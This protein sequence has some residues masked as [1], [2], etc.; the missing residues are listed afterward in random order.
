MDK[1]IIIGADHAGFLLKETIN[2]FLNSVFDTPRI[3]M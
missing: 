2:S 1:T 3:K